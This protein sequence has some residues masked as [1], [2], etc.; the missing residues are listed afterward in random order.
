MIITVYSNDFDKNENCVNEG[1]SGR[2][3]I[4]TTSETKEVDE[5]Y[6]NFLGEY[7]SVT[8]ALRVIISNKIPLSGILYEYFD[9]KTQ[10]QKF[11]MLNV[12]VP[13]LED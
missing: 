13:K 9:F 7:P 1:L 10:K 6:L 3:F 12:N 8:D 11:V 2:V 5:N 4:D